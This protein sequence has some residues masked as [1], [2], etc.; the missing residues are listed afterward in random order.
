MGY[1]ESLGNYWRGRYKLAPGKYATV[2]DA[3]GDAIRFRTK[4]AAKKA[5]DAEEAKLLAGTKK[6]PRERITFGAYVNRWYAAQDLAA[7]T[8][9]NYRR[10]IEEHLLPAFEDSAVADILSTDIAAWEKHERAVPYAASSVKTWRATL[11]L[12][13]ADA[14]D[15]GL[16]D[17]NPATKRRGRGKRAGRS[18][19]RGPEKAVTTALG[20]L[21]LA[22]RMALLSGRDDEFVAGI[23]KGYTGMRWGEIVGLEPEFVRPKSIRVEWQLYELDTGE[24]HRCPPKDDSYRDIDTP[25]FLASLLASHIARTRSKPCECHGLAYVFRGH[26]TANGSASRPGAKLVDVA[27]RSGVSTGTVSNVLNRPDAVAEPTRLKVLEAVSDLGYIRNAAS[28]EL[29]AHWRRSGFATWL[30]RP[31]AT[32]RYPGRGSQEERPVPVVAEPWPGIPARGRGASKRAGACWVPIAPGLTPHG[33]RHTHKTLMREVGTPPKLMDER[34]GHEDGSVQS[35]YD[36]I[37][38]GM[39]Q[40][41]MTALTGMWEEA[42]DARRTMSLGSPVAALDAVLKAR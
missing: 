40:S 14:V 33:L 29:A 34:M 5:A 3:D 30:F 12:I 21:L 18:R 1:A 8:M 20:I 23:V 41:L 7:S 4:A 37:T 25:D 35:R 31:A 15:E 39:R 22:E 36:H 16:R 26:G 9:Q 32:G 27:R 38:P 2:R 19:N 10:H 17:S 6:A 42:L 11:H 13:L 28:G 24:L